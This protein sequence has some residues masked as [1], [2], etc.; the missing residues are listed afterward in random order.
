MD[1]KD[2]RGKRYTELKRTLTSNICEGCAFEFNEEDCNKAPG[3]L[4]SD[5]VF[6]CGF[7]IWK[8]VINE[9]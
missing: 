1:Y 8:E 5:Y 2:E 4:T 7:S 9:D 3:L 6:K